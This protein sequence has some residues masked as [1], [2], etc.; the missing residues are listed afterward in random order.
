MTKSWNL[1]QARIPSYILVGAQF[2]CIIGLMVTG[3]IVPKRL[4]FL[5]LALLGGGI[6]CWATWTM[7]L[8]NLHVF[9]E[10]QTGSQLVL[11]GPYRHIRH[12]MYLAV[13]LVSLAWL[14]ESLTWWRGILWL[15]LVV[16]LLMKIR[17]E[18]RLLRDHFPAYAGYQT[19][20][21]RLL[22]GIF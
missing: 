4:E 3:P 19:R 22:P 5:A 6:A 15:L 13:L 14:M 2:L 18:E 8:R 21:S 7:K 12:P 11:E 16:V 17:L 1:T 9:P 10:V 20:T